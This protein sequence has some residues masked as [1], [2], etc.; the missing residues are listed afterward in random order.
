MIR[1]SWRAAGAAGLLS[2]CAV[3]AGDAFAQSPVEEFLLPQKKQ[4]EVQCAP[5][6]QVSVGSSTVCGLAASSTVFAYEGIRY[7]TAARWQQPKPAALPAQSSATQFGN[8]CPQTKNG[9]VAGNEDCLFLNV[10][11][12]QGAINAK[13]SLPVMVFI[14]GG[15]FISGAGSVGLYD[16]AAAA[17]QG[18]VVV[19]LNYRLGVLGF[20]AG[21]TLNSGAIIGGN[22][23][24]MDQQMAMQWVKDNIAA[25]GGDPVEDHAVRRKR[26]RDERGAAHLRRAGQRSAVRPR[27]HG[28]QPRRH[29]LPH[30]ERGDGAGRPVPQLHVQAG[31]RSS[32]GGPDQDAVYAQGRLDGGALDPRTSSRASSPSIRR[33]RRRCCGTC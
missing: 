22:F 2:L 13:Q 32:A 8:V 23:G 12:P 4:A 7:A 26:R 27:H 3:L 5:A 31:G 20:L 28:E 9:A 30:A 14:H 29:R 33:R 15:A 19:T 21:D 16:G 17:Q 25:F 11:T 10:W 1:T 6:S 24:L 18:V